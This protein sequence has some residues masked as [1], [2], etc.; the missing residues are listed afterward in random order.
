MCWIPLI[1]G[2]KRFERIPWAEQSQPCG[3]FHSR[4][5]PCAMIEPT[6]QIN[7]DPKSIVDT[8]V[9]RLLFRVCPLLTTA[10]S[11][12]LWSHGN[13]RISLFCDSH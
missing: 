1:N 5:D 3:L 2:T 4:C 12:G 9:T 6:E 13:P 7:K 8:A 10:Q 11:T